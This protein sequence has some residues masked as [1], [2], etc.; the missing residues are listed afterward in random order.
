V[1][2]GAGAQRWTI[3]A[4]RQWIVGRVADRLGI[5][6]VALDVHQPLARYGMNS[7][8]AVRLAAELTNLLGRD[9]PATLAYEYPTIAGLAQHLSGAM[10]QADHLAARRAKRVRPAE[11]SMAVVGMG[12]RFPG[13]DSVDAFW[14]LLV[15]GGDGT[16]PMREADSGRDFTAGGTLPQRAG[17]IEHV[18]QFDP[19]FFGVSPREADSIDPQ[20]RLLM[21]VVWEAFEDAAIPITGWAGRDVGVFIGASNNDYSRLTGSDS[22][23]TSG[24]GATG[25]SM[26]M[27]SNRISYTFDFRG[28]G[29]TID[30]ACSSSLV[31][32]H[33]AINSLRDGQCDL[34]VAG[35]VNLILSEQTTRALASAG[36]LSHSG[37]CR[38]F[39]QG[40]DGF[41]RG[42]GCGIVL[43]RP[44][45]SALADGNHIYAVLRGSA[46]NQ[47]GRSNGLT[48]PNWFAQHTLIE[49][50]LADAQIDPEQVDL[51]E[52]HGTGTELGDPLEIKAIRG[53]LIDAHRSQPRPLVIGSVK[54][55]IGHLEAA[56]G[57]AG[58]MKA[59]LILSHQQLVPQ[60]HFD[61]PSQ[62][63]DWDGL[64]IHADRAEPRDIQ[65][66]GVSSFGFGGT[67]A[68]VILS[69]HVATQSRDV[70]D[71]GPRLY[72]FS[73][74]SP[75]ALDTVTRQVVESCSSAEPAGLAATLALGRAHLPCRSAV[76]GDGIDTFAG[77]LPLRSNQVDSGWSVDWMFS[78]QGGRFVGAGRRL[79][80]CWPLFEEHFDRVAEQFHKV[81]NRSLA[82]VLWNDPEAWTRCEIQPALFCLQMALARSWQSFGILPRAVVGHSLGEY[83]AACV[84]GVFSFEDGLRI[85]NRRAELTAELPV[86]GGM[87]AVS[88]TEAQVREVMESGDFGCEIAA[89]NGPKQTVV[90]GADS[91]LERF[92]ER[93]R[94]ARLAARRMQTSHG[95]HSH[96]VDPILDQFAESLASIALAPPRLPMVSSQTG[97]WCEQEPATVQYWIANL[98]HGVRF[99]DALRT[100]SGETVET[101]ADESPAAAGGKASCLM[102]IGAGG[103]L[104]S[105]VK[106]S[107]LQLP[108]LPGLT[109]DE[110]EQRRWLESVGILYCQGAN[111]DWTKIFKAPATNVALP[112]YPFQRERCWYGEHDGQSSDKSSDSGPTDVGHSI[113]PP[114]RSPSRPW[115]TRLELGIDQTVYQWTLASESIFSHHRVLGNVVVPAAAMLEWAR[116]AGE[117]CRG[118]AGS[119]TIAEMRIDAPL[120]LRDEEPVLAQLIIDDGKCDGVG[121]IVSRKEDGWNEHATFRTQIQET[122][123][124]HLLIPQLVDSDQPTNNGPW[125]GARRI[126]IPGQYERFSAAGLDYGP[127]YRGLRSAWTIGRAACGWVQLDEPASAIDGIREEQPAWHPALLDSC[128]QV[129]ALTDGQWGRR[130]WLPVGFASYT[131]H[132]CPRRED[133]L[134]VQA[135]LREVEDRDRRFASLR[136]ADP[137]G[138]VLAEIVDLELRA[139]GGCD[140]DRWMFRENWIPQIRRFEPSSNPDSDRISGVETDPVHV[141]RALAPETIR[142]LDALESLAQR[143]AAVVLR[144]LGIDPQSADKDSIDALASGHGIA[145]QHRRLLARLISVAS[146]FAAADSH[147][148]IESL[149]AEAR[150]TICGVD[151]ELVLLHRCVANLVD[152]MRTGSDPLCLLFPSDDQVSAADIYRLSE[153]S[154]LMNALAADA[155]RRVVQRLP[156]GRGLRILE[157]GAG[158]GATTE[159]ILRQL[160]V[161]RF[162]YEFTDVSAGFLAAASRRFGDDP[163]IVFR[164]LDIER[165]PSEQGFADQAGCFDVV[166]AANV[167]HATADIRTSIKHIRQLLADHGQVVIVEGTRP[168]TWLDLTFGLTPGWWRFTD[169]DIR[170]DYPLLPIDRWKSVLAEQGFAI[171]NVFEPVQSGFPQRQSENSLLVAR[172]KPSAKSV[173]RQRDSG[174]W[175]VIERTDSAKTSEIGDR[176]SAAGANV[177][178]I[179][180][181]PGEDCDR[182]AERMIAACEA[183][184]ATDLAFVIPPETN[185]GS[186]DRQTIQL[187]QQI[188]AALAALIRRDQSQRDTRRAVRNV[189]LVLIA[190]DDAQQDNRAVPVGEALR[191]MWR[192][193]GLEQPGMRFVAIDAG[194]HAIGAVCDELMNLDLA[195]ESEI[196]FRQGTRF[197]RR[198]IPS[199]TS[200]I[201]DF[202]E[203]RQLRIS[204]RGSL[205]GLTIDRIPRREPGP[206]E[207]EVQVAASGLNFRDVLNLMGLYSA[208]VPLGAECTGTVC[209]VG[210]E[211]VDFAVGDRVVVV[212]PGTIARYVTEPAARLVRIPDSLTYAE[213]ATVPIAFLTAEIAL[214]DLAGIGPGD[215]VLIHSAAGGVG[216][217]A[218]QVAARVGATVIAT[219]GTAKHSLLRARGIRHV[220]D[221]RSNFADA[222]RQQT[223]GAGVDIVLNSL[224]GRR[225]DQNIRSLGEGGRYIELAMPDTT[226]R[227]RVQQ[228]ASGLIYRALDL[229]DMLDRD[230]GA[231]RER[232]TQIFRSVEQGEYSSLPSTRFPLRRAGEA[233]RL[234]RS[235][236]STGKIVIEPETGDLYRNAKI[237]P[238][239][240]AQ[241]DAQIDA[242]WCL[243]AGGLAG[244]AWILIERWI[245]R[246]IRRFA[247]VAQR[248]PT[249]AESEKIDRLI[250][251]G[252]E[253]RLFQ[254]DI[255][256]EAALDNVVVN[257]TEDGS[258]ITHAVHLAGRLDDA[259]ITGLSRESCARVLDPKVRG[260]WNLHRVT[261]RQPV[262]EFILFSSAAAVF[263]SPGQSNHAAANAFLDALIAWRRRQGLVG[264]S[265][266]W[267]P[268]SE[269]GAAAQRD[270]HARSDLAGIEPLDPDEGAA[271]LDRLVSVA[272]RHN[273]CEIAIRLDASR[274]PSHLQNRPLFAQL[275]RTASSVATDSQS[276]EFVAQLFASPVDQRQSMLIEYLRSMVAETLGIR[277]RQRIATSRPLVELGIDSLTSL[278]LT[279]RLRS[280]LGVQ[281]SPVELFNYPDLRRL[282]ARLV[283]L[284]FQDDHAAS[285]QPP[286]AR[287]AT[288][289]D[290]DLPLV[291]G[292]TNQQRPQET[293][294]PAST[295]TSDIAD[296]LQEFESFTNEIERWDSR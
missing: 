200:D 166:V 218:I 184:A 61:K 170:A 239:I 296:L 111:P 212:G 228:A 10:P 219:A 182:F 68:H 232:L 262:V 82:D 119:L 6:P 104:A 84:A 25:N 113:A 67:N 52:A 29:L 101:S 153:G 151:D 99:Y 269:V 69:R 94:H 92:A 34:A 31:A 135:D 50:A 229:T 35:G 131:V 17:L 197:V 222:V 132:Q 185:G 9:I 152:V 100:F 270:V 215:R 223:S 275:L 285:P 106:A 64:E 28:P 181:P 282:S 190:D 202:R 245:R 242:G 27:A 117:D 89:I 260:A 208:S 287:F 247:L 203:N 146:R 180:V 268:W 258:R 205:S 32:T 286:W 168:V 188:R 141:D 142:G 75:T 3:G 136:I 164:T 195:E 8:A 225:I 163:G 252:I 70:T 72:L 221:S 149:F 102:E 30:T 24:Y 206:A 12:C 255:C 250:A 254:A 231:V 276:A 236:S 230:F 16:R 23:G 160:P 290:A 224:D 51:V 114:V 118:A 147:D 98:R 227:Q 154:Q 217:A 78:G 251:G 59:C 65:I 183:N 284:V 279:N 137:T 79:H 177:E 156:A 237:D 7:L 22:I 90:A 176:L 43:L 76:V 127:G 196:S 199:E 234:L 116:L 18:D 112:T 96:L 155:V 37:I 54:A 53:A 86:A 44:L 263:G 243:V 173:V 40:A 266:N 55:N 138:R 240:V 95:F 139:T 140:I 213:A 71:S 74:S 56:A 187:V 193:V 165:D 233:F 167:L 41:V 66:A 26:A 121:R 126:D 204:Q 198:I 220:L 178:S 46:T 103:T 128:L 192:T 33:Q 85:V 246:G 210:S 249:V 179:A 133:R 47:D 110:N 58:L 48:A 272:G 216:M 253:V 129:V 259:T 57:I 49:T 14:R 271:I 144:Q 189:F 97:K 148:S 19:S 124:D 125:A 108:A 280:G 248:E 81:R 39:A 45:E 62:H 93:L 171:P 130:G 226:V 191:G 289:S 13:A 150:E 91:A 207:V 162:Q 105:L 161:G 157:I 277:D 281:I 109:A 2:D 267:G 292:L 73:A 60:P 211:V 15:A 264:L 134:W 77:D 274:L 256:D 42:E 4:L 123:S 122:K 120:M 80:A 169:T 143:S 20:H 11:R 21:E 172:C 295:A 36:M 257:L 261:L 88:A 38:A 5:D 186:P 214:C 241:K 244:L 174:N 63:F 201:G 209:R 278:E 265:I 107:R 293:D 1:N 283:D 273:D 115:G 235:G 159:G 158:T 83:A 288:A 194:Q 145:D 238:P 175:L 294:S 87:L 291:A